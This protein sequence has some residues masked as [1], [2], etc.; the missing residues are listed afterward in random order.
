M[1]FNRDYAIC[2][3]ISDS[4]NISTVRTWIMSLFSR[5]SH[6][7]YSPNV[8]DACL[9]DQ[10]HFQK[11]FLILSEFQKSCLFGQIPNGPLL[12]FHIY[13]KDIESYQ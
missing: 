6:C 10:V 7:I 9:L 5:V 2:V 12:L 1:D 13:S 8:S 4:E 3:D 11:F